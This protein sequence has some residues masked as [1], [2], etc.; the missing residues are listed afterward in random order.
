[1]DRFLKVWSWTKNTSDGP[2]A[3]V[4]V[5]TPGVHYLNLWMREDGLVIDKIVLTTDAKHLPTDLGPAVSPRVPVALVAVATFGT[6]KVNFQPAGAVVPGGYV[7]DGGLVYAT[8]VQG[9]AYGWNVKIDANAKDQN[10]ANSPDQR[11][12]TL[13]ETTRNTTSTWEIAV[14]NGRY[15]LLLVA[16]DP[17]AYDSYYSY[18]A[19]GV[20]VIRGAP[21]SANRWITGQA[22]VTVT[23]GRL[24]L[25][26]G[27]GASKNKLCFLEI[28]EVGP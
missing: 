27:T 8:Q 11:Y 23:D 20:A 7:K 16:G 5:A 18:E 1:M 22:T 24:T 21:T 13:I 4:T 2:P 10:A 3:T 15:A 9:Y 14:P 6:L 25:R 26:N 28:T 19:D 12:D 17:K